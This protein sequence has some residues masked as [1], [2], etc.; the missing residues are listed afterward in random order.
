M[1]AVVRRY[2]EGLKIQDELLRKRREVEQLL[3]GVPGFVAYYA[4]R[5]P[6]GADLTVTV[7][8]DQAGTQESTHVAAE[9]VRQNVPAAAGSS[10]EVIEGEVVLHIGG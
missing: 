5:G 3:R 9:W 6:G 1:Y 2:R 4:I 8:Q 7:C 10:P